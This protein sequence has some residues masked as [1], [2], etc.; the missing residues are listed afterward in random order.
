MSI[1][2]PKFT[3]LN[4]SSVQTVDADLFSVDLVGGTRRGRRVPFSVLI[5]LPSDNDARIHLPFQ[6]FGHHPLI[7]F[8]Y[9]SSIF[10]CLFKSVLFGLT[11]IYITKIQ[12]A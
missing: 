9:T 8:Q 11:C 12:Y 4:C 6:M 7:H 3:D 5:I 2:T 1:F 10:G